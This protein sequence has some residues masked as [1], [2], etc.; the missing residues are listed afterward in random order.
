MPAFRLSEDDESSNSPDQRTFGARR[1]AVDGTFRDG[2]EI[3]VSPS[4]SA[5]AIRR[6]RSVRGQSRLGQSPKMQQ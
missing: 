6:S 4:P 1:D 3:F 2:C 5:Q